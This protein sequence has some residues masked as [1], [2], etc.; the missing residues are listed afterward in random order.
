MI[1]CNDLFMNCVHTEFVI[2]FTKNVT[3]CL[4][5]VCYQLHVKTTDRIFMKNFGVTLDEEVM[6]IHFGRVP[7]CCYSMYIFSSTSLNKTL[8]LAEFAQLSILLHKR[9]L[10]FCISS[11]TLSTLK[12]SFSAHCSQ[13][14]C[15][16]Q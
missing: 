11:S 9:I 8:D 2:T 10:F 3:V 1:R 13:H 4:A 14:T 5:F 6:W 7:C 12:V 16:F 15:S